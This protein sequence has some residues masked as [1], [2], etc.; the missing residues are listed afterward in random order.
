MTRVQANCVVLWTI[1]QLKLFAAM[2]DPFKIY[3]MFF[4]ALSVPLQ[5]FKGVKAEGITVKDVNGISFCV[6]VFLDVY[7]FLVV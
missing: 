6:C 2:E 7:S 5:N 3:Q 1:N 4:L